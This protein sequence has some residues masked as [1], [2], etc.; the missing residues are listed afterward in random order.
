MSWGRQGKRLRLVLSAALLMLVVAASSADAR[1]LY[2]GINA[3]TRSW[4]DPGEEQDNV[5]PTGASHL[6][7]DI[8]WDLVEP[9]DDSWRWARTDELFSD[10][11]ERGLTIL[12]VLDS[13]PCWAVPRETAPEDCW[14][15]YPVSDAEFAEYAAA[16]AD[17]YGPSG[18][19]WDEHPGFDGDLAPRY[20]EVWNEPYFPS[21]TNGEVDPARY[22]ALYKAAV[23]A[24]RAANAATRWLYESN[25][26]VPNPNGPGWVNWA[27]ASVEAEPT[28]GTYIDGIAIH[29]Y[30]GPNEPEYQP[31]N[32][33]D[34]SF[35]Q[36]DRMYD[37]WV[38]VGIRRP[39]WITE[40]GY[41]SCDDEADRCVPGATQEIREALK[42]LWLEEL[43][44]EL[45]EDSY[46]YGYVHGVFLY[47]LRQWP[48]VA[49]PNDD[50]ESWFGIIDAEGD[51][52]PAW[53]AFSEDASEYDGVPV[54]NTIIRS[55]TVGGG[56]AR[57]AIDV[58][59]P[60]STLECKLDAAEWA[61]CTSPKSY[62]GVGG[63]RHT[64]QV[65]ATN[66]E[67]TES[68]PARYSW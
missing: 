19:F 65:R 67:A 21:F 17:R 47:N 33:T 20:F 38:E 44:D 57:F 2:F 10:A 62:S 63:G 25:V 48:D 7:E 49:E 23:I 55:A 24:G 52:L 26:D 54:P 32:G 36:T 14:R 58:N 16:L 40:V 60:T 27:E 12:P 34:E 11:A 31:E 28:I 35:K 4:E 66:V 1:N 13:S 53:E 61:S 18:N 68:G 30:P 46:G 50:F 6:R 29:P 15:T 51:P 59:D 41:S 37:D 9:S 42:A 39:F 43:L 5:V 56:N 45:V 22:A 8:Y 3:N 64:F